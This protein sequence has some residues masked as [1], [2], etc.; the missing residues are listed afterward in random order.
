[1]SRSACVA[2]ETGR[3][4]S[5]LARWGNPE[6]GPFYYDDFGGVTEEERTSSSFTVPSRIR[7]G[8]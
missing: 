1:M 8:W 6:G 4:Q 3:A 5:R 2:D 7:A